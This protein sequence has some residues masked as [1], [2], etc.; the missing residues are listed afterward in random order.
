[1]NSQVELRAEAHKIANQARKLLNNITPETR[2]DKE[3]EFDRMIAD[4]DALEA[5]ANRMDKADAF[6]AAY[7]EADARRPSEERK[8]ETGNLEERQAAATRNY[9]RTGDMTE[10]RA[11]SVGTAADGGILAPSSLANRIIEAIKYTGPMF[12]PSVTEHLETA[13][14]N[15]IT[16]PTSDDTAGV[17]ASK[18]ENVAMGDAQLTFGSRAMGAYTYATGVVKVSLE[19]LQDSAFDIEAFIARKLGERMGRT[20]NNLLTVGDGSSKPVGIVTGVGAPALTTVGSLAIGH[21]DLIDLIHSVDVAYRARGGSFMAHDATVQKLRKIKDSTG[22]YLWQPSVQAGAPATILGH[23]IYVNNDMASALTANAVP[24]LFGDFK[25]YCV[26][27]VKGL[28]VQRLTERYAEA[29]QVAFLGSIRFDGQLLEAGAVKG[30]KV[31][32]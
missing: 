30:I 24:V 20:Y 21:D 26:R 9:L 31:K 6:S 11:Q 12:D 17:G 7:D 27:K 8:V 28:Q 14:G 10:V 19:L 4:A 16:F 32:A 1:M 15:A 18:A 13:T 5:R 29:G 2:A 3:A 22:Q 25:S 23:A